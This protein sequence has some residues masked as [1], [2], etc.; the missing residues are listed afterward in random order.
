VKY[1]HYPTK[2]DGYVSNVAILEDRVILTTSKQ[3]QDLVA[4]QVG[5]LLT[6]NKWYAIYANGLTVSTYN[7]IFGLAILT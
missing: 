5:V 4:L 2:E 7:V 3:L 6:L 1:F